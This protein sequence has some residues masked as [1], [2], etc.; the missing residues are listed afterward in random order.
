MRTVGIKGWG[1]MT[2]KKNV[3]FDLPEKT[4]FSGCETAKILG[5]GQ[6]TLDSVIS[7]S[8]LPRIRLK[9]R[10]YVLRSDLENYILAHRSIGENHD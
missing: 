8:E 5:V 4:M 3:L 10:V 1:G 7:D 6:S 9:K 2:N